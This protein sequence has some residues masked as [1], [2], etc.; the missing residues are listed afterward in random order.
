[1]NTKLKWML[2]LLCAGLNLQSTLAQS[3]QEIFDGKTPITWLGLDYTQAKFIGADTTKGITSAVFTEQ[4]I[5]VY[6][7]A[8]NYLFITEP[9]KY[10][11]A[12]AIHRANVDYA[13]SVTEKA[14]SALPGNIIVKK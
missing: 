7:P 4:F 13:L 1:M 9:K 14:N 10:N 8:W 6:V 11:I 12:K 5:K 2:A 3:K